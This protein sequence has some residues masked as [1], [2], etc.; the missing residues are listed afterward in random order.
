M[1]HAMWTEGPSFPTERPEA[2]TRGCILSTCGS[3][4]GRQLLT[5]VILLMASVGKL[6]KP[7]MTKPPMIH[8]ISDMPEPAAYLA[9]ARTR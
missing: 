1:Q 4:R 2:I 9:R 7:R 6:R 8:L 5:S 3:R